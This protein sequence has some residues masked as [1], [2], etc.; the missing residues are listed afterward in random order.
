[1]PHT[2]PLLSG[3]IFPNKSDGKPKQLVVFLHGL[4]ADGN[5][6][7]SLAPMLADVLPD[8]FFTS[9]NAPEPCD[10][11]PFGYQWFSLRD[12]SYESMLEGVQKAAPILN[13]FLDTSLK[14]LGLTDANL[15]LVG[16]SQGTMTGLY[17]A[18]R[19]PKPCAAIIGFSGTLL[20]DEFLKDECTAQPP[21]CLIH[22][23]MDQVVPYSSL[24]AAQGALID[25]G[26]P[27]EAHTC[28]GLAHGIDE[29]GLRHCAAFLQRHLL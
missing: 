29:E 18:L 9:P 24:A 13:H 11:A 6:L 4:G 19:R 7:I 22:G 3:P 21:V 8:A 12:W 5:D 27:V 20:G 25:A 17:A 15:A 1:M 23:D 14:S 2:P 10:M 16:F 28:R 26:V